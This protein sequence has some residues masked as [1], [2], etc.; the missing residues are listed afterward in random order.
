MIN[1][2]AVNGFLYFCPTIVNMRAKYLILCLYILALTA[3][4][5]VDHAHDGLQHQE[6]V[7]KAYNDHGIHAADACSPFCFCNCCGTLVLKKEFNLNFT[8]DSYPAQTLVFLSEK[9]PPQ[10]FIPIWQPPKIS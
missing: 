2:K 9:M 5:C 4:P 8:P 10:F 6:K 1:P 3:A 7:M